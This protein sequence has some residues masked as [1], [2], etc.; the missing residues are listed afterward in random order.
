MSRGSSPDRCGVP[1]NRAL[2]APSVRAIH[3][4]VAG[5]T[6]PAEVDAQTIPYSGNQDG[7]GELP[8]WYC[9]ASMHCSAGLRKAT[10]VLACG[11]SGAC[12]PSGM[13]F[14]STIWHHERIPCVPVCS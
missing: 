2:Q 7:P 14:D 3:C 5:K 4:T 13:R 10:C 9:H 6:A 1:G 8:C 11:Q 12:F